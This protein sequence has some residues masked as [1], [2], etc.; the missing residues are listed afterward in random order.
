MGALDFLFGTSPRIETQELDTL[1]P[2]Q[3]RSLD[4]LMS[5]L[6]GGT[7]RGER[8]R[9]EGDVNVDPSDLSQLS[10]AG[11]EERS[12]M[13]SDPNRQNEIA[14]ASTDTLLKLLDFEGQQAGVDE[15]FNT[16]IRD[17]ALESFREEVL[18]QIGRSF[19]G[20]NFFSSE[21]ARAD[22]TA[23]EELLG[24]L[25]RSRADINFRSDQANR[26][27]ALQALGIAGGVDD[28]AR[29][30]SKELLSLLQAG[31]GQTGLAERNVNR[32]FQQF[33]AEAGLDDAQ[34]QQLLQSIGTG[35]FENVVTALPGSEGFITQIVAAAA[36]AARASTNPSTT[37]GGDE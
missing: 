13:L 33:L 1:T 3:R 22:D 27:R 36:G 35:A 2:E 34:I 21:R 23:R 14:L 25:T 20:A 16:N 24:S 6:S 17:P 29:G 7:G 31:E 30:D 28:I 37:I 4:Q 19:G 11:L 32:E 15:F 10:L 5:Q 26:D 18:P 8:R 12:L 9:F